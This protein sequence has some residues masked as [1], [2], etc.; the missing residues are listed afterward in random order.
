MLG[1]SVMWERSFYKEKMVWPKVCK[2][3]MWSAHALWRASCQTYSQWFRGIRKTFPAD[4][5]SCSTKAKT[6]KRLPQLLFQIKMTSRTCFL[7]ILHSVSR[8]RVWSW[9]TNSHYSHCQR[10]GAD[11]LH[12][13][14]H[15]T[16]QSRFL[17]QIAFDMFVFLKCLIPFL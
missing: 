9:I 10:V 17:G 3:S 6:E 2:S 13:H 14:L 7:L 12:T 8:F 4:K 11:D 1:H 16:L 15:C 5:W